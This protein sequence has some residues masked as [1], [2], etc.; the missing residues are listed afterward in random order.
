MVRS[1]EDEDGAK[2]PARGRMAWNPWPTVTT[3]GERAVPMAG[4]NGEAEGATKGHKQVLILALGLGFQSLLPRRNV[5]T[6]Q[7]CLHENVSSSSPNQYII[8]EIFC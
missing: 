6:N 2:E 8:G 4:K 5:S 1:T 7:R 3:W